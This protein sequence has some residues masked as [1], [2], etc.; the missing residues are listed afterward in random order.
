LAEVAS[1]GACGKCQKT[2]KA[3]AVSMQALNLGLLK[4]IVGD[5]ALDI[6]KK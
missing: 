3:D 6:V 2:L 4:R 1:A 5:G